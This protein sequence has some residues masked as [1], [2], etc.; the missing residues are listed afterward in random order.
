[1]KSKEMKRITEKKLN[2]PNEK[3]SLILLPKRDHWMYKI[4]HMGT[5]IGIFQISLGSKEFGDP[6]IGKMS[7]QLGITTKQFKDLISCKFWAKDFIINS[8]LVDN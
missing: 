4:Y 2:S 3:L 7:R 8:R 1:M 6:L 5:V